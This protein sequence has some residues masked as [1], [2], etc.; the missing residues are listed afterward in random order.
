MKQQWAH[1]RQ[2]A[3]PA[4]TPAAEEDINHRPS[5]DPTPPTVTREWSR[6]IPSLKRKVTTLTEVKEAALF[7]ASEFP[8]A[9]LHVETDLKGE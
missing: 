4:S 3:V 2:V 1:V 7:R 5:W 9:L 6:S 8:S